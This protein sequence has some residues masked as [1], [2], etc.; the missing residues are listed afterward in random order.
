M[1]LVFFH[2]TC[3]SYLVGNFVRTKK[4]MEVIDGGIARKL[5]GVYILG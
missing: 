5:G 1:I 2:V 3:V 4:N